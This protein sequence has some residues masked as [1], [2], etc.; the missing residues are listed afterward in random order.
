[1]K[2]LKIKFGLLFVLLLLVTQAFAQENLKI[3]GL[4]FLNY[5]T[6]DT[7]AS[8]FYTLRMYLDVQRKLADNLI[9]YTTDIETTGQYNV[10]TKYLYVELPELIPSFKLRFGQIPTPWGNFIY[11][12]YGLVAYYASTYTLV[13]RSDIFAAAD[14]GLS[15]S[16]KFENGLAWEAAYLNGSGYKVNDTDDRKDIALMIGYTNGPF[17]FGAH[18]QQSGS[19]TADYISKSIYNTLI[20]YK[21]KP[22][23]IF[24][25]TLT[26]KK[27]GAQVFG[28]SVMGNF[29]LTND[30][31]FFAYYDNFDPDTNLADNQRILYEF[32]LE[33]MIAQKVKA[34]IAWQNNKIGTAAAVNT[35]YLNIMVL[36]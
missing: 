14:R 33:K 8:E 13:D 29:S 1:M 17:V 5:K 28:A 4:T 2:S 3:Q 19:N 36:M 12:A 6:A 16:Q 24:F 10:Y 30:T 9:R 7:G 25:E 20:A 34:A 27:S 23:S 35:A 15:I 26:G 11:P 32:G 22:Y 31:I 21:T 18:T